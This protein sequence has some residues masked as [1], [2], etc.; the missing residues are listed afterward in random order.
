MSAPVVDLAAQRARRVLGARQA[1]VLAEQAV[2]TF[3]AEGRALADL[4]F[5]IAEPFRLC[6]PRLEQHLTH[7]FLRWQDEEVEAFHRETLLGGVDKAAAIEATRRAFADRMRE[8]RG[9]AG[10][11]GGGAA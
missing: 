3:A 9:E 1:R 4:A 8:L 2:A 11:G 7:A 10:L 6:E 5:E